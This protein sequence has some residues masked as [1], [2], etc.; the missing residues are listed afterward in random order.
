MDTRKGAFS[1]ARLYV[2]GKQQ[3]VTPPVANRSHHL[4][5]KTQ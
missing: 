1:G 2:Q 3:I 4:P 5:Y